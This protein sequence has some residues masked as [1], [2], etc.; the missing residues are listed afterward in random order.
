MLLPE[1]KEGNLWSQ[2][3]AAGLSPTWLY[4]HV[5]DIAIFGRDVTI[6]K[7]EITLEFD[8]KDI[9]PADLMLGIKINQFDNVITLDQ[10]YFAES[11]VHLYGMADCKPADT[12]LMPNTHL[13][14]ATLEDI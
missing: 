7:E 2:T 5:D 8:I 6:F 10:H 11:L 3:G 13:Q 9:G 1:A 14:P 4:V 12:P